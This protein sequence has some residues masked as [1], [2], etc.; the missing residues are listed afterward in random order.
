MNQNS[1]SDLDL[2][3]A[4]NKTLALILA[5][6]RCSRLMLKDHIESN[7][8]M[9]VACI[10]CSRDEAREF[11]VMGI[12]E[13]NNITTFVAK[14]DNPP[15]IPGKPGRSLASMGIYI[16]NAKGIIEKLMADAQSDD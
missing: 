7:A 1:G 4:L 13:D 9:T 2:N 16:F 14:P 10:E 12:D 3:G 6:G 8:E 11:G 15:E 5:G